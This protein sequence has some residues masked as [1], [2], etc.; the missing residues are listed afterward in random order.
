MNLKLEIEKMKK[1][2]LKSKSLCH[3]DISCIGCP[4]SSF[5][6]MMVCTT[7]QMERWIELAK[8]F[9]RIKEYCNKKSCSKC[10]I[11][12]K[13]CNTI[14]TIVPDHC[15]STLYALDSRNIFKGIKLIIKEEN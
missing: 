15:M 9:Q 8:R 12:L 7:K 10:V 14:C 11:G 1:R 6:D 2:L 4:M 13:T 3:C 5:D